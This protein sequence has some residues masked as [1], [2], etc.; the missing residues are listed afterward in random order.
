MHGL[1]ILH[2]DIKPSNMLLLSCSSGGLHGQI[3]DLGFCVRLRPQMDTFRST[4]K[5]GGSGTV[6][7]KGYRDPSTEPLPFSHI[8]VSAWVV[9]TYN[10]N[11]DA[12][13]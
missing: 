3:C 9:G 8:M 13:C 6:G 12:K 5:P 11:M 1:G 4:I 7:T 10:Y 2:R